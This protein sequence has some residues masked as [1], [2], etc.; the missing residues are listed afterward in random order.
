MQMGLGERWGWLLVLV[1]GW[2]GKEDVNLGKG[3]ACYK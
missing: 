3:Q 1:G 2:K